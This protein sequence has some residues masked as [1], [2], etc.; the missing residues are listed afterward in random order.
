MKCHLGI[1][2]A[3]RVT[4][5]LLCLLAVTSPSVAAGLPP[6]QIVVASQ[7]SGNVYSIS[8]DTGANHLIS[9]GGLLREPSHVR[10]DTEGFIYSAERSGGDISNG[11]VRV[12]PVLETR[13]FVAK[14]SDSTFPVALDFNL[15]GDLIV[16]DVD[17]NLFHVDVQTGAQTFITKIT[18]IEGLQDVEVDALG[19]YLI[20]DF[21]FFSN[22]GKVVRFDPAAGTQ[23]IVAQGGRLVRIADVAI[24]QA[25]TLLVSNNLGTGTSELV[26]INTTTGAQE[27]LLTLPNEGFIAIEDAQHVV[28]AD[29]HD[30][31]VHRIDLESKQ[32]TLIT[33]QGFSGNLVG[34][35]VFHPVPE[36][37][38]LATLTIGLLVGALAR[39]RFK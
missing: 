3:W 16:G 23:Q 22:Q 39:R 5:T 24:E 4:G 34:I 29:F 25:G 21:S 30:L 14:G 32:M 37:T 10:I 33:D 12:D 26:R 17:E 7:T 11:I 36:P 8:P 35:D 19:R 20:A 38:T 31:A 15:E 13:T 6:G 1:R 28:Y 27:L 9:G 2:H 18:G